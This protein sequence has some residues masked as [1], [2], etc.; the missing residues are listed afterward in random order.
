MK[1]FEKIG[2]V[3]VLIFIFLKKATYFSCSVHSNKNNNIRNGILKCLI[4]LFALHPIF[5]SVPTW[6]P[7]RN[8]SLLTVFFI[9]SL[10]FFVDYLKTKKRTLSH[11]KERK[12]E[13][14]KTKAPKQKKKLVQL[15]IK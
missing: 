1:V 7:A 4:I 6:L 14:K 15:T 2:K 11:Q 12:A 9:F 13:K 8:D 3:F 10:I 5:A